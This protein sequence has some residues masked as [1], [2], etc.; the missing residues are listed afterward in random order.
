RPVARGD[1]ADLHL[2]RAAEEPGCEPVPMPADEGP[3]GGIGERPH[4]HDDVGVAG[5]NGADER[6]YEGRIVLSVRVEVDD[7]VRTAGEREGDPV[8][9]ARDEAAGASVRDD[10]IGSGGERDVAGGVGGSV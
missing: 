3:R 4:A 6:G 1:V 10:P 2:E 5:E 8:V 7:G 9:E